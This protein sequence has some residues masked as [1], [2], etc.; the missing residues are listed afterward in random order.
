M[1]LTCRNDSETLHEKL[2][3]TRFYA[4]KNYIWEAFPY[5]LKLFSRL[6]FDKAVFVILVTSKCRKF[7]SV[8]ISPFLSK[9]FVG[10]FLLSTKVFL[11]NNYAQKHLSG[12]NFRVLFRCREFMVHFPNVFSSIFSPIFSHYNFNISLDGKIHA[13]HFWGFRKV[14]DQRLHKM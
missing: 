1:T 4:W 3:R 9:N 13:T 5:H 14:V 2:K 11:E 8:W 10:Y 6:R 12:A 7:A